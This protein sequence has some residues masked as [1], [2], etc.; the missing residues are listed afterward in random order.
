MTTGR[1]IIILVRHGDYES[2]VTFPANPD[3]HL[4]EKGKKQSEAVAERLKS[5]KIDAIHTSSL[6]RARETT[7]IMAT[8]HPNVPVNVDE[9]L[10]ECIPPI[11]KGLESYFEH[12]PAD[13]IAAGHA[14]AE[15]AFVKYFT[16]IAE[17]APLRTEVIVG[18]GNLLGYFVCRVFNAPPDTWLTADFGNC[19]ISQIRIRPDGFMKLLYHN[20]NEHIPRE[21]RSEV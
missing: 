15:Q 8:Y 9:G 3:G 17:D 16:P 4:N 6:M 19:A 20:D 18:H 14:Q 7:D 1:K 2:I 21:L 13:F 5:L 12:I 10:Q 11:P